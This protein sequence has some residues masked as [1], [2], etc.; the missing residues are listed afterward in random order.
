MRVCMGKEWYRFPSHFFLPNGEGD[1]DSGGAR[2]EFLKSGFNGQLPKHF[3]AINGTRGTTHRPTYILGLY[4]AFLISSLHF[5]DHP[6]VC[7]SL[8]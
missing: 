7:Y 2:L 5:Y 8:S 1:A 6:H 4:Y 3:D